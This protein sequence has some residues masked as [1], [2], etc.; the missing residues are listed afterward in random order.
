[1]ISW[2]KASP[3]NQGAEPEGHA[4]Q[5]S[6]IINRARNANS[7]LRLAGTPRIRVPA[8]P[9]GRSV[10]RLLLLAAT[11]WTCG[12]DLEMRRQ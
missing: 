1:M 4:P 10:A 3:K 6:L 2:Q 7:I 11:A 9:S 12:K 8:N 5:V